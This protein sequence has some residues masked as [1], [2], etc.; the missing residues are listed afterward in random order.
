MSKKKGERTPPKYGSPYPPQANS[1]GQGMKPSTGQ[2]EP[3]QNVA[4]R[5]KPERDAGAASGK[6]TLWLIGA[7]ALLGAWGISSCGGPDE[8]GVTV[9]RAVYGTQEDCAADWGDKPKECEN[10]TQS[11]VHSSGTS[12]AHGGIGPYSRW[13]GPYYSTD[14]TVYHSDGTT[15]RRAPAEPAVGLRPLVSYGDGGQVTSARLADGAPMH[16]AGV[17]EAT[18][19][20]SALG[21]GRPVGVSMRTAATTHGPTS[22]GGFFSGSGHSGGG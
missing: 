11:T 8:P 15:T 5:M 12:G 10:V 16:A 2:R 22:R 4:Y 9:R 1:P 3:P 21:G 7:S 17:E 18:L 14:G 6:K 19:R 20:R 13:Y